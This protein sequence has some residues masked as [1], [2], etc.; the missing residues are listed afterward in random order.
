MLARGSGGGCNVLRLYNRAKL[1]LYP[2][3]NLSVCF[4]IGILLLEFAEVVSQVLDQYLCLRV[5]EILHQ[6]VVN[7][8]VLTLGNSGEEQT[9]QKHN[10]KKD[11][12]KKQHHA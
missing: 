6:G 3:L 10:L 2:E 11:V 5:A 1:R 8:S 9:R 7:E 12:W 4:S